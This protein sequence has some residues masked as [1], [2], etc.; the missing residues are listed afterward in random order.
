LLLENWNVTSLSD[1]W[2]YAVVHYANYWR[3]A[4]PLLVIGLIIWRFSK[5][6]AWT[7]GGLG[8]LVALAALLQ[9]LYTVTCGPCL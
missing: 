6:M 7:I 3:I 2:V 5:L 9:I 1:L 8:L 4:V